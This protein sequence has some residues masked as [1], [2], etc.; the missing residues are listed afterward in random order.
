[1]NDKKLI[2]P[3]LSYK[4][5]GCLFEVF[6]NIGS[7]RREVIYQK[8]LKEEFK[9]QKISF[10]EQYFIK[11]YYKSKQIGRNYFDFL[12]DNKIILEIKVGNY[13]SKRDFDQILEYLK[14]SRLKLGI[15]VNF[16]RDGVKFHRVLNIK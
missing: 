8:A 5:V 12:I 10:K 15:I 4:I 1:M 14:I 3:E 6:N 16:T 9:D 2:Y 11:S 7:N 13:F